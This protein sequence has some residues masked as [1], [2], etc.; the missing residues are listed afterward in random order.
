MNTRA[1]LLAALFLSPVWS[2]EPSFDLHSDAIKKIV[3]DNASTQFAYVQ[4][5]DKAPVK[6]ET[7]AFKYVPPEEPPPVHR[8]PAAAARRVSTNQRLPLRGVRYPGR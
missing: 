1:Y 6:S 4:V 2:Q 3:R 7:A 5:V 8:A